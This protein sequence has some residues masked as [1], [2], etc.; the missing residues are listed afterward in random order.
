MFKKIYVEITNICNLNCSFCP[1]HKRD[2]KFLSVEDFKTLLN[3]IEKHTKYL[4]FHIMGEPLM[5]PYI[6]DLINEASKKFKVN[7]T[8]NGYLIKKIENNK[9]IRQINISLHSYNENNGKSLDDYMQDIF[10]VADKIS[11]NTYINY[12]LWTNF[13]EKNAIVNKLRN[14]Y[15]AEITNS[16]IKLDDN[17]YLDFDE[18][19]IWPSLDNEDYGEKGTCLGT[20][21]HIGILV[22]GTIVPCCLDNNGIINL[23]NIYKQNLD[24]IISSKQFLNIRNGFLNNK[25]VCELC[26]KC[27][28]YK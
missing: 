3:K 11:K 9:N 20:R 12:R 2:K 21:N 22:D 6:N 7:I 27:C 14:K 26:R 1:N 19:F 23:G 13:S 16:H 8:T 4:Y 17:I 28:F 15:M 5:H 25:K 24:D 18:A 10:D